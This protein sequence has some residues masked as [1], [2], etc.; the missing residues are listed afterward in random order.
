MRK[1]LIILLCGA[2]SISSALPSN[3]HSVDFSEAETLFWQCE[4]TAQKVFL[5]GS[6]A[7]ICSIAYETL[8]KQKFGNNFT[9][10]M[11]WWNHSKQSKLTSTK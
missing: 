2:A 11:E 5:S 6:E 4:N 9:A 10:F 8:L 7:A 1:F 3:N